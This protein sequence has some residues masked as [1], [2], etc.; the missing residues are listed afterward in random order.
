MTQIR[1]NPIVSFATSTVVGESGERGGGL[2]PAGMTFDPRRRYHPA[3]EAGSRPAVSGLSYS[4]RAGC[5]EVATF[6]TIGQGGG[7]ITAHAGTNAGLLGF[8]GAP[9][10]QSTVNQQPAAV[11]SSRPYLRVVAP[12]AAWKDTPPMNGSGEDCGDPI[13]LPSKR[14]RRTWAGEPSESRSKSVTARSRRV[15]SRSR[16]Y[17]W[18]CSGDAGRGLRER[19]AG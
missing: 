4:L 13:D 15:A 19:A 17:R 3:S 2:V 12:G 8:P 7:V 6:R 1:Y 10:S 9:L 16:Y 11:L 18:R 14:D 5:I